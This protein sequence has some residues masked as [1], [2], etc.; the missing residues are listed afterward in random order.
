MSEK[1]L[2]VPL[3]RAD[4]LALELGDTVFLDG[5]IVTTAGYPT[6]QRI[7]ECI[8]TGTPPPVDLTGGAFFHMGHFSREDGGRITPVYVNPTTSTRFNAFMPTIIRHFGLTATAGKGGLDAESV[9]AMQ[10]TGCVYFSMIG[11]AAPLLTEGVREVV[12]TGWNDL[13][14][15][16][17]LTRFRVEHFGPLTVAIDAHGHSAYQEL[18]DS[19]RERVSAIMAGLGPR[20]AAG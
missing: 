17:R 3:P 14:M 20:R 11:G 6:H 5:E 8:R 2:R 10:E 4:L 18:S 9:R 16:F 12:A 13:I 1:C 15:Q 7:V 19:A